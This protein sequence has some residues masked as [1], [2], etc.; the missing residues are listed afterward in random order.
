MADQMKIILLMQTFRG[1][2]HNCLS[3]DWPHALDV[4][5]PFE[6]EL[7]VILYMFEHVASQNQVIFEFNSRFNCALVFP[8]AHVSSRKWRFSFKPKVGNDSVECPGSSMPEWV[9][10]YSCAYTLNVEILLALYTLF[11]LY[12]S[13]SM[14]SGRFSLCEWGNKL[15]LTWKSRNC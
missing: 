8:L 4:V 11:E 5:S 9:I 1:K 12:F 13:Q 15:H 6:E 7:V 14:L 2:V 3:M 10:T